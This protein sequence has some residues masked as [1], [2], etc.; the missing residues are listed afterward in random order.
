MT[1]AKPKTNNAR[2]GDRAS[3]LNTDPWK[4]NNG[5]KVEDDVIKN[6]LSELSVWLKN[7]I[8]KRRIKRRTQEKQH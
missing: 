5:K 8:M 6:A 4:K 3:A 2:L 7:T 1:R